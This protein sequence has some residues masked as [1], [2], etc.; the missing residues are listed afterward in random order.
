MHNT[1]PAKR[2]GR[3]TGS[4][5]RFKCIV[6]DQIELV[7]GGSNDF[8]CSECREKGHN[9]F[10]RRGTNAWA[11]HGAA[12]SAVANA[13]RDGRLAPPSDFQC[14]DCG[15]P[16]RQYDH[17]DYSKPLSVEPVCRSCNLNRGPAVPVP[18]FIHRVLKYGYVPYRSKRRTK[19][20]L[21]LLGADSAVVDSMGGTL[22]EEDWKQIIPHIAAVR[23]DLV[24]EFPGTPKEPA[25]V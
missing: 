17:R 20:L 13:I 18:G 11:S 4:L 12:M 3:P 2:R 25:N 9:R 6:C 21:D 7:R 24:S 19:Q 23:P 10:G 22:D 15:A 1:Q 5:A 14:V 8:I 16:A